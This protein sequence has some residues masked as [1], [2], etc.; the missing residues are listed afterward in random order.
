MQA[1]GT[2]KK[3]AREI[4]IRVVQAADLPNADE[5]PVILRNGVILACEDTTPVVLLERLHALLMK[6]AV[7]PTQ[8]V[9]L[10]EASITNDGDTL[11]FP[12]SGLRISFQRTLRIPDDGDAHALPPG[13]GRYQLYNVAQFAEKLPQVIT[14]RGG[15]L[16]PMYENEAM[17]MQFGTA[18]AAAKIG[19]GHVNVECI[20]VS[21]YLVS[22]PLHQPLS[23]FAL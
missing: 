11:V 14:E 16:L 19:C 18:Q 13:L 9:T 12:K 4:M 17:W 6:D 7:E 10:T 22:F 5:E 20:V 1:V 21:C 23:C 8:P 2:G 15:V 3:L